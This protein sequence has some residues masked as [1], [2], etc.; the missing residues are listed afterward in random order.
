[1]CGW[2][3]ARRGRSSARGGAGS[4]AVFFFF[5]SRRRH[6]RFSRDWSSDVCSSDLPAHDPH[7]ASNQDEACHIKAEPLHEQAEQE[8]RDQHLHYAP[9][10]LAVDEGLARPPHDE[11]LVG[12]SVKAR[13]G[14]QYAEVEREVASLRA[15]S[16]PGR[17][18]LP[19]V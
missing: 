11:Q 5:S 3:R 17:A 4:A 15:V 12:E 2:R 13:G 7:E 9:E 1:R 18:G 14:E 19:I 10:L 6:T 16:L 8:G